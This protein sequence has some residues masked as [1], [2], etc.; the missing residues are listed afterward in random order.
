MAPFFLYYI[1]DESQGALIRLFVKMFLNDGN[2]FSNQ[3]PSEEDKQLFL[4]FLTR[5]LNAVSD[6]CMSVSKKEAVH[7]DADE[8]A[9]HIMRSC[10]MNVSRDDVQ[11]LRR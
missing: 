1:A 3:N 8:I 11:K 10:G 9:Y 7:I 6:Y 5:R 4:S 2:F